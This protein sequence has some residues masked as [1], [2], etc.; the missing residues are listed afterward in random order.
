MDRQLI[1]KKLL[2]INVLDKERRHD[3][4]FYNPNPEI[5]AWQP[6][7]LGIIAAFTPSQQWDIELIDE[8][9][10]TF[11]Y[12]EADLVALS[13]YTTSVFRAY[14]I[15]RIYR[16]KNIPV[17]LGGY[18]A[19][20]FP[21][22]A[23]KF[24]DVVAVGKAEGVWPHILKDFEQQQLQKIYYCKDDVAVCFKPDRSI[25]DKY[26][27]PVATIMSSLGCPF[28]CDFCNGP[29]IQ[30]GH[31]YLRDIDETVEEIKS[32]K[33]KYFIFSDDNFIGA[34]QAHK[35][36]IVALLQKMIALKVN[37]KWQC[38]TSINISQ[39]LDVLKLA[40]KAGCVLM[41]IGIES[42][43]E[44][45]LLKYN[46]LS[47]SNFFVNNYKEAFKAI[48]KNKIALFGGFLCNTEYD[49]I[50]D[51]N[52]KAD[53]IIKSRVNSFT[54]TQLT[55]MPNTKLFSELEAQNRLLFTNFPEDWIYYN[56]YCSVITPRNASNKDVFEAYNR[57]MLKLYAIDVLTQKF[58][59]TFFQLRSV[60]QTIHAYTILKCIH[61]NV[62]QSR[63]LRFA[64]S[65]FNINTDKK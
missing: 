61:N 31:Y 50:E 46:K 12:K 27:Y 33:Q 32:I 45:E 37:K 23:E 41:Y 1:K 20:F 44:K 4:P 18:H 3:K 9:Y 42:Y 30:K 8:N 13:A 26:D 28:C 48:H 43:D 59:K 39:H 11:E 29:T 35:D 10:E 25:F 58:I 52:K 49:D 16:K 36:R 64:Q 21:N 63:L 62:S 65:F 19:T 56:C 40:R 57:S 51:F 34:T 17:V 5:K 2:L 22:E 38:A 7:H 55:P 6:V 54:F 53:A 15:A 60:S 24:V 47:N 14:Q